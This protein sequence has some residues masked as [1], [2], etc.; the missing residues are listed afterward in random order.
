MKSAWEKTLAVI[1]KN[2][3]SAVYN[4]FFSQT[5][6]DFADPDKVIVK[7]KSSFIKNN[8]STRLKPTLDL[9]LEEVL[10]KKLKVEFLVDQSIVLPAPTEEEN[11][12]FYQPKAK[13]L[14]ANLNP[15]YTLENF[16]VGLSNNLAYAAA[17]AVLQNPGVSYNPLFIYGGT[18]VGKTHLMQGI[19]QTLLKQNHFLKVI[20]CPLE[21]FMNDFVQSIQTKSTNQFR[22]KYRLVDLLLIDDIQFI[23]GRDSTQEEFFNTFNALQIRNAQIVLTSDRPPHEIDKLEARLASRFQG[24][25]MVDIQQPDFDT[26]VAILK[27]KSLERGEII[28][29]DC[30]TVIAET[31][32]TNARELEGKLIQIIQQAKSNN[33]PLTVDYVRQLLGKPEPHLQKM[34][35]KKVISQINHYFNIKMAEIT[36]PRRNKELVIPRQL[37]MY[38]LYEECKIPLQRIGQLLGGRDHTTILHG[39]EKM[40]QETQKNQQIQK[41]LGEIKQGLANQ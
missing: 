37:A 2:V 38:L 13:T 24:G 23:S 8:L 3:S 4:T 31:M 33:Q 29:E 22:Q 36:G 26:R 10:G 41:M 7:T 35:Y 21:T 25:L 39:V 16:V 32:A 5:K 9:A 27:A 6:A 15:K 30:L 18:G 40:R 20:Y 12:E 34:D 17:K 19:G 1:K 14:E 28:A 11:F